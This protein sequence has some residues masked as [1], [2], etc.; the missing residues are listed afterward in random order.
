MTHQALIAQ[1]TLEEKVSLLA[2]EDFW[3]VPG[4]ARLGVARWRVTDGPIGARGAVITG[5]EPSAAFPCG[6]ALAATWDLPLVREVG[7]SL[8]EEALAKGA[9]LLLAPTVNLH[10]HPLAGRNFECFSEDPLLTGLLASAYISGVQDTG[11]GAC[12][13]HFACNESEFERFTISSEVDEQTLREVY[14][15]PFQLALEAARPVAVMSAYNRLNGTFCSEHPWLLTD[16]LREEWGYDGLVISDWFGTHS[17]AEALT[18]GL[19]VE[20][21]GPPRHRGEQLVAA[22]REGAVAEAAV[23]RSVGRL[24][25][26]LERTGGLGAQPGVAGTADTPERRDLARRAA[27]CAIV[28]LRN[29]PVSDRPALPLAR[30]LSIVLV[31]PCAA[32]PSPM[33]G[34][35][36][37]VSPYYVTTP[38]EE[39]VRRRPGDVVHEPG[40]SIS[41]RPQ[42]MPRAWARTHDGRDGLC[43]RVVR[44]S[45]PDGDDVILDRLLT[46]PVLTG[47]ELPAG[48]VSATLTGALIV[49]ETGQYDVE[50]TTNA[51]TRLVVDGAEVSL[52]ALDGGYAGSLRLAAGVPQA[53]RLE[54]LPPAEGFGD[55]RLQAVVRLQRR[56]DEADFDR[57]VAAAAAADVAVV[58]VGTDI[59]TESEGFDR[60][61]LALPG[62]QNDLVEAV[63]RVNPRTVVVLNAGAPVELPWVD[64]VSAVLQSWFGGQELGSGL[65]DVLL[66]DSDPMGRLPTTVPRRLADTPAHGDYPGEGGKVSYREKVLVGYPS[67]LERGVAPLFA[68]GH[69]L[70]YTSFSF[71]PP[72]Y[73]PTTQTLEIDVTNTGDRGGST[74]VQVYVDDPYRRLVGFAK[75]HL[76][77]GE[78]GSAVVPLAASL[79]RWNAERRCWATAGGSHR[80]LVARSAEDVVA[81]LEIEVPE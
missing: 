42:L 11:V 71:G 41:T 22:V 49:P 56:L 53:L 73:D 16:V 52:T 72:S 1:M 5:G 20:M 68:F 57:A 59:D 78:V 74:V 31:G 58:V 35:S 62:R 17:T 70:S 51:R 19:D 79:E 26:A 6:T 81:E 32:A 63:A 34:G 80:L 4:V 37:Q 18:A 60:S 38:L 29:A 76:R 55:A 65:V 40:C 28:L 13:K 69:G 48:A 75:L 61:T 15:R 9:R 46:Y 67:Y 77:A 50:V 12:I 43:V 54:L 25:L 44:G 2:G 7:Q 64:S 30:G 45:D 27:R 3:H 10:R 39:L 8:G 14:L 66:G 23:D 21:P 24:L 47:E 33:G 36:A